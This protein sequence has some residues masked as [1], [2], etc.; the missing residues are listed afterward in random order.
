MT[1]GVSKTIEAFLRAATKKRKFTVI[2]AESFPNDHAS[3]HASIISLA[4]AG[5]DAI[6]IP[7]AAVFALMSRVNKVILG[8]HVGSYIPLYS[9]LISNFTL[10]TSFFF[11][12]LTIY[13]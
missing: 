12:Y 7:D 4:N 3:S 11:M 13:N 5:I 6:L 8:A 1:H 10:K 9:S 2:L